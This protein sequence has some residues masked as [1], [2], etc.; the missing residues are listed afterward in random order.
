MKWR[1]VNR[2]RIQIFERIKID[3]SVLISSEQI[4]TINSQERPFILSLD[5]YA[6]VSGYLN[7]KYSVNVNVIFYLLQAIKKAPS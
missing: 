1:F 5:Y 4:K 3:E 6:Y 2:V 7:P